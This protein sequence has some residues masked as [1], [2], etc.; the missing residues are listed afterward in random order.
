MKNYLAIDPMALILS[1]EEFLIWYEIHHPN[2]P[3]VAD[4]KK[5]MK[6]MTPAQRKVIVA[7]AKLLIKYGNTII[8]YGKT[9]EKAI[10]VK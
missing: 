8:D 1:E 9:I 2:L 6:A 7:N 10:S 3:L 5:L 4:I